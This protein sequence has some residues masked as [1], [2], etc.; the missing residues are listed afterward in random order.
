MSL[1]ASTRQGIPQVSRHRVETRPI[2]A[3]HKRSERFG[4]PLAGAIPAWRIR[5]PAFPEKHWPNPRPQTS[6]AL[7]KQCKL[8]ATHGQP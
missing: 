8:R 4:I 5:V 7:A 1:Q 6:T 3:A 2:K